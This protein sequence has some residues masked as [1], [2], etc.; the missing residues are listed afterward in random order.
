MITLIRTA[1]II[2]TTLEISGQEIEM[3]MEQI[4]SNVRN[5]K[6]SDVFLVRRRIKPNQTNR[7]AF[8]YAW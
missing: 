4:C 2:L 5:V 8:V 6:D 1:Y 7:N 3:E